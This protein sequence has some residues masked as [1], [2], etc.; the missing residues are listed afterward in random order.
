M[1]VCLVINPRDGQNLS[2]LTAILAV[3]AAAGWKTDVVLK[4]YGGHTMELA[5][6]AATKGYDQV[7]AYGGDGTLNQVV[8]GLMN[9]KKHKSILG[10]LPGGTVN[11][12]A[13]EVGISQDPVK[14]ALALVS[15][16]VRKVDVARV[17]VTSLTLH[18]SV[19]KEQQN[20]IVDTQEKKVDAEKEK[21]PPGARQYF[22]LMAGLGIDAAIMGRVNKNLKHH[23]GIAAV[24]ITATEKL[25]EQR[26]F[27]VEMRV[28]DKANDAEQ[29]WKGEA[30]Q[31]VIGNTRRYANTVEM[32]ADA[33]I[34]DGKLDAAVIIAGDPLSTVQQIASLLFRRKPD[35]STTEFFRGALLS[36]CVPASI[37][38]QLDGSTV[39]LKDFLSKSDYKAL[40]SVGDMQKVMVAYQFS[41]LPQAL[42]AAIPRTYTGSL[43]ENSDNDEASQSAQKDTRN[44]SSQQP[45]TSSKNDQRQ[46]DEQQ[47]AL[48]E[49]GRKVAVV[50]VT[51][52]PDKKQ[53]Y[54]IAG[55]TSKKS[56][57][58]SIPVA[59]C[60]DDNTALLK[61]TGELASAI[62]VEHLEENTEIVV[63]GKKS[64][65]GVIHAAHMVI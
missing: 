64:K 23:I 38:L 65:R 35:N 60:V 56:T 11:Q 39:K 30:L 1:R 50:G 27:P 44:T 31:V 52:L 29:V 16:N 13:A 3:F 8:N 57:G 36:I 63:E 19:Q 18:P 45:A 54:I 22:L 21:T 24:G 55:T 47:N 12:W 25:P 51:M 33:S 4:E 14:A 32:T 61:Q 15:S 53:S 10:T 28:K 26:A 46:S 20:S 5:T 2:K 40:E 42:E 7:I 59:I 49:H 9:G 58:E 41:A 17:D 48:I 37:G 62:D 34:D 43:F 6:N